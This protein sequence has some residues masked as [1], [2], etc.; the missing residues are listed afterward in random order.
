MRQPCALPFLPRACFWADNETQAAVKHKREAKH[1]VN[2]ALHYLRV[3][4]VGRDLRALRVSQV[5]VC[6]IVYMYSS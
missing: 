3:R 6:V 2:T 4:A 1:R 5:C